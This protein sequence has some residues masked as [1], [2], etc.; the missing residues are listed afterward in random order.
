VQRLLG[1][2]GQ[3]DRVELIMA[4]RKLSGERT[5]V[6]VV[7]QRIEPSYHRALSCALHWSEL[8]V[9]PV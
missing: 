4:D 2:A 7:A 9:V 5:A 1:R 3:L 8:K 6:Q